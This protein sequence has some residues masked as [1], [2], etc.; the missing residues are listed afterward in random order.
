M[1]NERPSILLIA[2]FG[3]NSN[4]F[5]GLSDTHL[6]RDYQLLPFDL[7]GFGA[8]TLKEETTLAALAKSVSEEAIK[9]GTEIIVAHSVASIVA[10]LA[11]GRPDCPLTTIISLEGNITADDAYFS[12][13]AADHTDPDQFRSVFLE[14]L[15]EMARTAPVIRRYRRMVAR[16][17]PLAL[18]QLGREA[19]RYSDEHVP[20]EILQAAAKVSYLYNPKN[21]PESTLRWLEASKMERSILE[22][23]SHWPTDDQPD[24]TADKIAE[25]LELLCHKR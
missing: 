5:S 14:R 11:A 3:D 9:T 15:D 2:G 16:A 12:G 24:L 17:D 18:W 22:G 1:P 7:P 20:G 13:T 10:A 25:A 23:A 19:R 21:C 6:A 8:P 4:M